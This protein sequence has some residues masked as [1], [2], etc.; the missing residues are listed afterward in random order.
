MTALSP[1]PARCLSKYDLRK[2]GVIPCDREVGL[3]GIHGN[4]PHDQTWTDDD[5]R[6]LIAHGPIVPAAASATTADGSSC[7]LRSVVPL[8]PTQKHD[9]DEVH[10]YYADGITDAISECEA[11]D[12]EVHA[13][14]RQLREHLASALDEIEASVPAADVDAWLKKHRDGYV[15]TDDLGISDRIGAWWDLDAVLDDFRLHI[16][17][18]TPL[19]EHAHEGPHCCAGE[20]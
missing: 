7:S 15:V 16:Q 11:R 12:A 1:E 14:L 3:H 6:C 5:E 17:T 19:T 9:C 20:S 4:A 2:V 18:G 8:D 10:R 13:E